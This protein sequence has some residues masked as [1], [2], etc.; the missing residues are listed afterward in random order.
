MTGLQLYQALHRMSVADLAKDVTILVSKDVE[1]GIGMLPEWVPAEVA[2]ITP[3]DDGTL[4]IDI[5]E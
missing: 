5:K 2:A 1:T 4:R 3:C